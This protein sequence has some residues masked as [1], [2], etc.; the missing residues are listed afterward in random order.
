MKNALHLNYDRMR[1][2]ASPEA[3]IVLL[4]IGEDE[5]VVASGTA[6]EPDQLL[7]LAIGASRTSND[8][9]KH[10]PPLPLEI[11]NAIM[12]IEDEVTRVRTVMPNQAQLCS[13][14]DRIHDMAN[15][16]GNADAL[17]RTLSL[18]QVEDLF[19]Q[20][21][22]RSEGRPATQVNI[23]DDLPFAATLLI[24]CEFM[25]HLHFDTLQCDII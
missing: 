24:L 23:P 3:P 4:H 6:A 17:V 25:H 5:T 2:S 13:V 9:F 10:N 1:R 22:A 7:V 12:V 18:E 20:L 19:N 16:L 14:D 15:L 8:F 21:A 11:E